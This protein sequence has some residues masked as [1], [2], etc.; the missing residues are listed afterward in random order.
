MSAPNS[1]TPTSACITSAFPFLLPATS[2]TSIALAL[3]DTHPPALSLKAGPWIDPMSRSPYFAGMVLTTADAISTVTLDLRRPHAIHELVDLL[4]GASVVLCHDLAHVVLTLRAAGSRLRKIPWFDTRVAQRALRLGQ[5]GDGLG[6]DSLT[7]CLAT[8]SIT[9]IPFAFAPDQ[10]LEVLQASPGAGVI[11]PSVMRQATA[12]VQAVAA[13]AAAQKEV[14]DP[15]LW[16]HLA[17]VEMPAALEHALI[18]LYGVRL[19]AERC[20]RLCTALPAMVETLEA[21][22]AHAG[23]V[24]PGSNRALVAWVTKLGVLDA[25]ETVQGHLC[26][27]DD[28]LKEAQ[29][30]CSELRLLRQLRRVQDLADKPWLAGMMTSAD[31]RVHPEHAPLRAPTTRSATRRPELTSLPKALRPIV[32]ADAGMGIVELDYKGVEILVAAIRFGDERLLSAYMTG[33]VISALAQVIFTALH[34]LSLRE[35]AEHH[36]GERAQAKTIVYGVL[37]GR[38]ARSL[39]RKLGISEAAAQRLIDRLMSYCPKV[40]AGMTA[41]VKS[42]QRSGRIPIA[43]GLARDLT[44]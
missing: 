34:G 39:A 43:F 26:I 15:R 37:Y 9:G 5:F 33:D 41:L 38:K 25:F 18:T 20:R 7:A 6:S 28:A 16:L 2:F 12:M 8:Y 40:K 4:E 42:A 10:S 36:D 31:G 44:L 13:I 29:G 21:R 30:R 19:D 22:L 27:D 35:V 3:I 1:G 32:V 14:A 17:Q 23:L 11:P 24:D